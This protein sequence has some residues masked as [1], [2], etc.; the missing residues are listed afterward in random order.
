VG[1]SSF[2]VVNRNPFW[3]R[4]KGYSGTDATTKV[5]GADEGWLFPPGFW[6][7]FT[8]QFPDAMSTIAVPFQGLAAGSGVL[9]I[10]YGGGGGGHST[11]FLPPNALQQVGDNGGSL[12]IDSPQLPASMGQKAAAASSPVVLASDQGPVP[13]VGRTA[14]FIATGQVPVAQ[15]A[16][17]IL[18]ARPTRQAAVIGPLAAGTYFVGGSNVSPTTGVPVASGG[19]YTHRAQTALY[20]YMVSG[21]VTLGYLDEYN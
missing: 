11:G 3:V 8:T 5:I 20:A 7:I 21:T 18:P 10:S 6:G 16:T 19:Y 15:S 4:P 2:L 12:T 17:L 9:E 14:A 13:T 1:A